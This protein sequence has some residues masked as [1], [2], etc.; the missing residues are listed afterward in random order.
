M[1]AAA[2]TAGVPP[3]ATTARLVSAWIQQNVNEVARVTDVLLVY[4][5]PTLRAQRQA[6]ID[7]CV[8]QLI[9][10]VTQCS[11]NPRFP[12]DALSE[13][14]ANAEILPMFG[15]PTRTRYLFH[16]RPTRA[17]PWPPDD[18]VDRDLDIAI[19]QFAPAMKISRQPPAVQSAERPPN[20][21]RATG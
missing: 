7:Y 13:R 3:G 5:D 17:Y 15:F 9:P 8:Q 1:V 6:L 10:L 19:S 2:A 11:T 14:L 20:R 21:I 12:Q 18:V 4:S 16:D